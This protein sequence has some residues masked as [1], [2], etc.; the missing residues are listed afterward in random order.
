[1]D[2]I[3]EIE[4]E[5]QEHAVE[6]ITEEYVEEHV[7]YKSSE[8]ILDMTDDYCLLLPADNLSRP[9]R[10]DNTCLQGKEQILH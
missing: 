6:E 7:E 9:F 4:Q 10:A 1:M 2:P 8:N 3:N 5:A